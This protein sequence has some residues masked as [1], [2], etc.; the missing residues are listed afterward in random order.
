MNRTRCLLAVIFVALLAMPQSSAQSDA[1]ELSLEQC[2]RMA[3]TNNLELVS[4]RM[5]PTIAETD[6]DANQANFDLGYSVSTSHQ[7][8]TQQATSQFDIT[9]STIDSTDI[10]VQ[11]TL[12]YGGNYTVNF[13]ATKVDQ[14]GPLVVVPASV[15]TSVAMNYTQPLLKGFG[16]EVATEQL[17]LANN[18][19]KV[20]NFD[21]RARAEQ[22][23]EQV[24]AA[25]WDVV[26]AR[27]A[28]RIEQLALQRAQELLDQNSRMVEVGSLAPIEITQA[29]AGVASQEESVILAEVALLDE[30]GA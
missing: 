2:L 16:T 7:Q 11:Q 4:A 6:I 13:N 18:N 1:V 12:R 17:V 27:E 25:Y 22:I 3:L 29:E 8:S 14:Q 28:L 10:G 23:M 9:D 20:S 24:E 19:V 26:A 30:R 5:N 15:N 21:L